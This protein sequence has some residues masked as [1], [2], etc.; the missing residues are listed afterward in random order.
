MERKAMEAERA[1]NKYKQV[2]YMQQFI[3]DAFDGVISGVAHFG[4]WVETI[5]TK[6]EGLVSIHNMTARD[7]F[8]HD[9]SEYALV[10][11]HTGRR[12][13]IGDKVKIRVMAANLTKRQLDYDLVEDLE[14]QP[15]SRPGNIS[16]RPK[17]KEKERGE[18]VAQGPGK[19]PKPS[20]PKSSK[21]KVEG[22]NAN[23][24]AKAKPR[25]RKKEL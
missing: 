18:R 21:P 11:L 3:G 12:F 13:R 1:A 20:K 19:K 7:E 10:G 5:D 4:F 9:E 22:N 14:Q 2:E 17:H 6:C 23:K 24:P 16:S 15:A 8:K 25:S